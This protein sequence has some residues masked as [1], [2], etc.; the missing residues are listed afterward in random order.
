MSPR[1]KYSQGKIS[2]L[3]TGKDVKLFCPQVPLLFNIG[4]DRLIKR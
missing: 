4:I 1:S 3:M 2:D